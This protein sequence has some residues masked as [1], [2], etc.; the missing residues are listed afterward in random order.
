M[1]GSTQPHALKARPVVNYS[2]ANKPTNKGVYSNLEYAF[3]GA[4]KRARKDSSTDHVLSGADELMSLLDGQE[5][6]V[7]QNVI[8]RVAALPFVPL[9]HAVRTIIVQEVQRNA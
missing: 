1:Y 7:K 9:V 2:T 6:I 3:H 4:S 5:L 8:V